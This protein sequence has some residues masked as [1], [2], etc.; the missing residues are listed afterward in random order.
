MDAL[1]QYCV[2]ILNQ[3][4]AITGLTY[5]EANIWIFV[6]I[7]PLVFLRLMGYIL[8]LRRKVG[9]L[10]IEKAKLIC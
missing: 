8:Y 6:I 10:K 4:A 1:F 5:E 2:D 3:I 7:E 9:R